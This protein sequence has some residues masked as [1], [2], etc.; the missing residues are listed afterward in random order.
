MRQMNVTR[1]RL[2]AM[3]LNCVFFLSFSSS[4]WHVWHIRIAA[5]DRI[6]RQR[7]HRQEHIYYLGWMA[8]TYASE[9]LCDDDYPSPLI[10]I[11]APSTRMFREGAAFE[12]MRYFQIT[13]RNAAQTEHN[14]KF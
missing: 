1:R 8:D 5:A 11:G 9:S 12:T 14:A 6:Y 4:L 3:K 13:Y 10:L 7:H 2:Y